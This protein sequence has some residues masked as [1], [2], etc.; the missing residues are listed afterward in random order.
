MKH[1]EDISPKVWVSFLLFSWLYLRNERFILWYFHA[2]RLI[3]S[4][5]LKIW[6]IVF[7]EVKLFTNRW[8]WELVPKRLAGCQMPSCRGGIH[9]NPGMREPPK[10]APANPHHH[11]ETISGNNFTWK[12]LP[13]WSN[14]KEGGRRG[15]KNPQWFAIA[16]RLMRKD[17]LI[18]FK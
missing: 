14:A 10:R 6:P 17:Q 7:V 3:T 16:K 12:Y 15:Y 13:W 9:G 18:T 4:F 2:F 1:A 8:A 11:T 5:C